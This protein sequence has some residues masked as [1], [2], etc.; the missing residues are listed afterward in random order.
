MFV[1]IAGSSALFAG[2]RAFGVSFFLGLFAVIAT[3]AIAFG[4]RMFIPRASQIQIALL[5]S[6]LISAVISRFI[7]WPIWHAVAF[8]FALA[9]LVYY[10]AVWLGV[11]ASV[12]LDAPVIGI[13]LIDRKSVV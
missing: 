3:L 9:M 10:V 8:T 7:D 2:G 5:S 1:L 6:V 13:P 4:A 12:P 11:E